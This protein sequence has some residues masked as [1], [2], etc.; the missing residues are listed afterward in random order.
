MKN[1]IP[2]IPVCKMCGNI[3]GQL[4]G[5]TIY[6]SSDYTGGKVCRSCMIEHCC[7][8]NCLGCELGTYPDCKF[9]PMKKFYLE[10]EE[11]GVEP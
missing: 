8:T 7:T 4:I 5:D 6:L 11:Q 2:E 1:E 10:D 3:L 9:L